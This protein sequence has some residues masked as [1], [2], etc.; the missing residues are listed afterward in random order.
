MRNKYSNICTRITCIKSGFEKGGDAGG[1]VS[2][3]SE[4]DKSF[5][6]CRFVLKIEKLLDANTKAFCKQEQRF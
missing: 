5:L 6:S 1:C 4:N 2:L 3:S